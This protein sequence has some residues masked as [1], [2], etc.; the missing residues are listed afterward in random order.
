VHSDE[1][2]PARERP[3]A[4]TEHAVGRRAQGADLT[5]VM[6]TNRQPMEA[7]SA[8]RRR[9]GAFDEQPTGDLGAREALRGKQPGAVREKEQDRVR[10]V[11]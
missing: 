4:V 9:E 1:E 7:E 10:S 5:L 3:F 6:I 8:D 2:A 11:T